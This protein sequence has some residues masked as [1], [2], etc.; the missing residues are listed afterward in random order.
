MFRV[1]EAIDFRSY[2][3]SFVPSLNWD[4]LYKHCLTG[5][6]LPRSHYSSGLLLGVVLPL[7]GIFGSLD[8]FSLS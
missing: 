6:S 1:G 3:Y 2:L 7:G 4:Y 8:A 5:S